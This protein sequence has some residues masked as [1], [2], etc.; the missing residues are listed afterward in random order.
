MAR[1]CKLVN[2]LMSIRKKM[3]LPNMLELRSMKKPKVLLSLLIPFT[4]L[5]VPLS[6]RAHTNSIAYISNGG[7]S[8]TFW[9]GN[10]HDGTNFNEGSISL[11]GTSGVTYNQT[12]AFSLLT[13]TEPA[14]LVPGVN[15]F[16][17]D[18]TSLIP[19]DPSNEESF[20]WQGATFTS[21]TSGTYQFTYIPIANPSA[22]WDPMDSVILSSSITL[23]D[24]FLASGGSGNFV[25]LNPSAYGLRGAFNLETSAMTAGLNYDCITFSSEGFC[26]SG[27]GRATSTNNP[28]TNSQGAL[29][30]ASYRA[31]DN[32]RIGGYLDQNLSSN[33]AR[34]VNLD[35]NTPM[36][37]VFAAWSQSPDGIGYNAR[38]STSYSDRGIT[39]KRNSGL[40]SESGEGRSSLISKAVLVKVGYGMHLGN[41]SWNVTP[42]A[43]IRYAK[44]TRNSYTEEANISTPISYQDLSQ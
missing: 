20:T 11:V 24:V 19:Y 18:G 33:D 41:S 23:T 44:T 8:A 25:D 1:F 22:D 42:Y 31:N 32:W 27:G 13:S 15:Y 16:N 2:N 43:G 36:V 38:L 10:W 40:N 26:L 3:P 12:Q 29:L 35:N 14:G 21:L 5:H 4:I 7:G 17:S 30:I 28:S 9:Y 6:S 34:G 37:G 39:I